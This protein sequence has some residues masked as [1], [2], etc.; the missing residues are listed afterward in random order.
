MDFELIEQSLPYLI[1]GALITIEITLMAVGIGFF[2][3]LFAGIARST[4]YYCDNICR[5]YPWYT[6]SG[7]DFPYILCFTNAYS[8]PD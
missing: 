2:I 6:T 3:G 7:A 8:H 5:L 1:Q 4:A